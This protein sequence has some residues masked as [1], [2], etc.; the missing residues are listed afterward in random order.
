ML[1]CAKCTHGAH[2][3]SAESNVHLKCTFGVSF[4]SWRIGTVLSA[5]LRCNG[6]LEN[7]D[8]KLRNSQCVNTHTTKSVTLGG[9]IDRHGKRDSPCS[10]FSLCCIVH[11]LLLPDVL[12]LF[13]VVKLA[14][15]LFAAGL[16]SGRIGLH[17][18]EAEQHAI[19]TGCRTEHAVGQAGD[20]VALTLLSSASRLKFISAI[21]S[22]VALQREKKE[23]ETFI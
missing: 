14:D 21:L 6:P 19:K 20:P 12:L 13:G 17:E 15:P 16:K 2:L 11:L 22:N 10:G 8:H 1:K 18:H 7:A 5:A 23:Q 3:K 9:N 4:N